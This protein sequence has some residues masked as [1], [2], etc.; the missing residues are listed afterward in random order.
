MFVIRFSMLCMVA[1]AGGLYGQEIVVTDYWPLVGLADRLGAMIHYEDA[2]RDGDAKGTVRVVVEK[3]VDVRRALDAAVVPFEKFRVVEWDGEFCVCAVESPLLARVSVMLSD[4]PAMEHLVAI[5][6]AVSRESGV[7]VE[8]GAAPFWPN[9]TVVF[10]AHGIPAREA[11][12]QLLRV[13]SAQG[14]SYRLLYDHK[15]GYYVLNVVVPAKR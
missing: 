12:R 7:R 5:A 2:V 6:R 14:L 15:V 8:I 10:G 1:L 9:R 13:S 4:R 3:P 11:L